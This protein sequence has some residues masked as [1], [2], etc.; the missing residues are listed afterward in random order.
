MIAYNSCPCCG[1][2]NIVSLFSA[3]DYTVSHKRF[4]IWECEDC[5]L[6]F[7]QNV[8]SSNEIGI[9]Y[10]SENY[11][12]HSDTKEGFVNQL[13]HKVRN[14][15]LIQKRKWVEAATGKSYGNILDVGCGTGAFLNA[16]KNSGWNVWGLEP[17][18]GTRK[19]AL[20]L[21]NLKVEPTE[22]LFSLPA[23]SYDAITMWHVLEHVH[24]LHEYITRLKEL[25]KPNGKLFIAVPNFTCYD[26]KVYKQFWA[27]YDVP[28]HLYHFSPASIK[29]LLSLHKMKLDAIK[30]M[31]YDSIYVSMLSEQ[32]KT[33]KSNP[34]KAGLVGALSNLKAMSDNE[35]C[36][37]VV[38][39]A[40]AEGS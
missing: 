7:T 31:W 21:Y 6:R 15:T 34:V 19:R 8:P 27:A 20:D 40:S 30:P 38:Y 28:R 35:K 5:C 22:R 2:K 33:G 10:Q 13:Y 9:Y 1:Q 25:L 16:M 12:S 17:D 14:R 39:I 36:S 3:E 26:E 18:D 4:E 37:S 32:Y 29:K 11:I 23:E 24:E